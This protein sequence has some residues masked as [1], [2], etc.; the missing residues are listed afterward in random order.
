MPLPFFLLTV[1]Q[2]RMAMVLSPLSPLLLCPPFQHASVSNCLILHTHSLTVDIASPWAP[3]SVISASPPMADVA[4]Q[5]E[6]AEKK[7]ETAMTSSLPA[8][9]PPSAPD[10]APSGFL[11]QYCQQYNVLCTSNDTWYTVTAGRN[12]GIFCGWYSS[13][14]LLISMYN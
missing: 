14:H 2:S 3:T 13:L 5:E 10:D 12:V 9:T 1:L 8:T 4:Q 11:C 7:G 6:T